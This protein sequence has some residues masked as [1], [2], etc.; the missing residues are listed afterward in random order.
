MDYPKIARQMPVCLECGHKI[1]YGRTDKK[2]CCD[3]CRNK[4]NNAQVK[5][6]RAYKRRVL[7]ALSGNYDILDS[8][9]KAGVTSMDAFELVHLGFSLDAVTSHR[10]V[11]H[12]DEYACFDIKYIMTPSRIS[13]ITKISLNLQVSTKVK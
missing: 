6:G 2:F 5:A 8:L 4:H 9:V 13:G 7:K 1:R 12:H 10:R 11:R 3:K